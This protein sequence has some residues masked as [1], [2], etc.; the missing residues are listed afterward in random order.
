MKYMIF[1]KIYYFLLFLMVSAELFS[2]ISA[3]ATN[4]KDSLFKIRLPQNINAYQPAIVPVLSIDGKMLYFDRTEHPENIGGLND[5]DDIWLSI[6]NDDGS[7]CEPFNIGAPINTDSSDVLF[8]ITPDSK[9]AL[10]YGI[11]TQDAKLK[12]PGFSLAE[13]DGKYIK[14]IKP[15]NITNYYNKSKNFYANLSYDRKVLILALNRSD[16]RGNLDLYVSFRDDKT[17]IWS[18]P[19]NL[20]TTINT[21][22]DEGS[23]FLSYDMRTLFFTS[24]KHNSLGERD[25]YVTRRV[26]DSWNIWTQPIN[27]GNPINTRFDENGI[28]VTPLGDSAYIVSNDSLNFRKGLYLVN[29]PAQ[30]RPLPYAILSGKIYSINSQTPQLFNSSAKFIVTYENSEKVDTFFSNSNSSYSFI[31]PDNTNCNI[32]VEADGYKDY[33]FTIET[34]ILDKPRYL[35]KDIVLQKEK[36]EKKLITTIYFDFN[37][38]TVPEEYKLKLKDLLKVKDN[39]GKFLFIGHSDEIGSEEYNNKLSQK[40]AKNTARIAEKL[41]I[42][43]DNVVVEAKGKSQPVSNEQALNRRVEIYFIPELE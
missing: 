2:Q 26:G 21:S 40:R 15:L 34:E 7:W 20:G 30:Y 33:S 11:Y 4:N 43:D 24:D 27:L 36:P 39:K 13:I 38:D 22:G 6:K 14:N 5:K 23:P 16:S 32:K 3:P 35:T 1:K 37:K 41:G 10:L 25:L 29:I 19:Q 9:F 42:N 18:E 8:T 17:D 12:L 31:L 28:W